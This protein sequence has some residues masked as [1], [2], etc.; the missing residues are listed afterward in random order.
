MMARFWPGPDAANIEIAAT[1][2][3]LELL[4]SMSGKER[5]FRMDVGQQS[6][7]CCRL[8]RKRKLTGVNVSLTH[9]DTIYSDV[10]VRDT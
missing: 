6:V 3:T 1:L 10:Q 5:E 2:L 9:A 4:M 8:H 7:C